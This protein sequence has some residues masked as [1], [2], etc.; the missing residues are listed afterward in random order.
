[1]IYERDARERRD[2]REKVERFPLSLLVYA[3][4][5]CPARR[6]VSQSGD[7]IF[8]GFRDLSQDSSLVGQIDDVV[9]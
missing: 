3:F 2:M 7:G 8:D 1:M 6:A 9:F 5:A 4:G